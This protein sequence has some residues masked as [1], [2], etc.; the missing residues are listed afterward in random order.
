M[1]AIVIL[2]LGGPEVLE[3]QKR[4]STRGFAFSAPCCDHVLEEKISLAREFSDRVLH[5]FDEKRIRPVIH[6]VFPF[7]EIRRA[8]EVMES[9]SN[10]GKIVLRWE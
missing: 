5:L 2:K 3:H 10:F 1:R 7:S 4:S 6:R 8:H 9:G